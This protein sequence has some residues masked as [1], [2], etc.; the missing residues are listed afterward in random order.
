MRIRIRRVDLD[1]ALKR[2]ARFVT[3]ALHQQRRAQVVLRG[4]GIRVDA[5]RFGEMPRH[6]L[7]IAC[8]RVQQRHVVVKRGPLSGSARSIIS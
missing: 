2:A 1:R 5:G 4:R 8:L 3:L 7:D 6:P